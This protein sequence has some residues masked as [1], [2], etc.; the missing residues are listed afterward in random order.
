MDG[1]LYVLDLAKG[2]EL[3]KYDLGAAITASPAVDGGCLV[4]GTEK[5]VL[6]C[7]GAKK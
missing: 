1:K 7:L 4:I 2:T 5:G 3:K 6:Y